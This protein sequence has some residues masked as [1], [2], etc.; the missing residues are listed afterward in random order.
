MEV[1][2]KLEAVAD[3]AR[4]FMAAPEAVEEVVEMKIVMTVFHLVVAVEEAV[5]VS[6]VSEKVLA[7]ASEAEDPVPV[8][9]AAVVEEDLQE[10]A[11]VVLDMEEQAMVVEDM[12][13]LPELEAVVVEEAD[14]LS[15]KAVVAVQA[16]VDTERQRST[17]E[18]Q[19]VAVL[20]PSVEEEEAVVVNT[21]SEAV[22]AISQEV[23]VVVPWVLE[24]AAAVQAEEEAKA[25]GLPEVMP[26]SLS[27]RLTMHFGC[28][29]RS[30][31]GRRYLGSLSFNEENETQKDKRV[32]KTTCGH[33]AQAPGS[34]G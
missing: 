8:A 19:E 6:K 31:V 12:V 20:E 18:V 21:V 10:E 14:P 17:K 26:Y 28:L 27:I 15:E 25:N 9:E 11:V 30:L 32:Q 29:F 24:A 16:E 2:E 3:R 5:A 4:P 22:E 23:A 1:P 34:S 7:A 13:Q 33:G